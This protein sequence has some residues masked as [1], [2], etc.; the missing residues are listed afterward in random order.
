MTGE[1]ADGGTDTIWT[2]VNVS[3]FQHDNVENLRLYDEGGAINGTGN[4][5]A[6]LITGNASANRIA[7]GAGID[8]L[9]GKGG[10]DTF[11]FTNM[12]KANK[13][14]IWDFDADDKVELSKSAFAGLD[15]DNDGILDA[16]ALTFGYRASGT[17]A[18]IIYDAK[19]GNISYDADGVGSGSPT[20]VIALIGK[21]L[22]F[23]DHTDFLLA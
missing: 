11:V 18:Q 15:A 10:A 2:S 5:L 17:N 1:S 19:T 21:N 4:E 23:I 16:G 22:Q 20:E 9:Y 3:L 7:G 12:G 6:N 13:D 14:S 8:S